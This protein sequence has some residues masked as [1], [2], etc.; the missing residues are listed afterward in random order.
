LVRTARDPKIPVC[1]HLKT[2]KG[3]GTKKTAESSSGAH[4]F[5]LKKAEE[6]TAFL[7]EIY[8]GEDVP[9]EFTDWMQD[10]QSR[11]PDP[12]GPKTVNKKVQVGISRALIKKRRE[13]FPIV[14]ISSD[15][16]GSTGV[17]DFQ[18][19]FPQFTQDVGVA[20]ANMVSTAIGLSKGGYIPVV[21]TFAQFGATKGALPL[22]M[23]ALSE[24]PLIAVFSHIGFQDAADGASHQALSY[25]GMLGSIPHTDVYILT[26]SSEAEALMSQAIEDFAAARTQGKVPHSTV[27]FL[28]RENFPPTYLAGNYKYKLGEAQVVFDNTSEHPGQATIVAAGAL[29][30]QALEAAYQLEK[31]SIG[32]AV[33][34]PSIVNK[35]DITTIRSCLRNTSSHLVTV[36]DHQVVG[37]MGAILV[38]ALARQQL[39]V[40]VVSLGV[41]NTFGQSAYAANDLYQKHGLDAAAIA[42]AVR[43]LAATPD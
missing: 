31:E 14:S 17:A 18:K 43:R 37:G 15:L 1:L 9:T 10:I 41:Q 33:V 30:H 4:G 22:I 36:D 29:L 34:N 40:K 21:D 16:P 24:G 28:G 8:E 5:P 20:E 19:E 38:H 32:V 11:K 2:I 12:A 7:S 3:Y 27:F 39:P 13:G 35:P 23:S 25:L 6:L 42:E 26:S